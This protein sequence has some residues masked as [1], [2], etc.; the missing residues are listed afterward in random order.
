MHNAHPVKAFHYDKAKRD[1]LFVKAYIIDKCNYSCRY[2][3]NKQ[4]RSSLQ[5]DLSS[6]LHFLNDA[7][8]KTQ[9]NIFLEIIGGEPTLHPDMVYFCEHLSYC[10]YIDS[11]YVYSNF[12][13]P[14]PTYIKL[15]SLLNVHL[16]LSWHSIGIDK[17]NRCFY[18]KAKTIKR[19]VA[20]NQTT[21]I[22]FNI[23]L[24]HT[25]LNSAFIMHKLIHSLG[26]TAELAFIGDLK[27]INSTGRYAYDDDKRSKALEIMSQALPEVTIV[28]SNGSLRNFSMNML[29]HAVDSREISFFGWQCGAGIDRLYV[30]CDQKVYACQQEY[31]NGYKSIY[32]LNDG[33]QKTS[34]IICKC[35]ACIC[36]GFV[37]KQR[38]DSI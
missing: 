11:I 15:I 31:E 10:S 36:E 21:R 23:M 24:E 27:K 30:H 35:E 29:M 26:F 22:A 19:L 6:L 20:Q 5:L 1:L 13:A 17:L 4:P 34:P 16:N 38:I 32:H 3:Y 7:H 2:C 37:K 28:L 8:S 9:K 25:N 12:S 14:L 33:F 18:D